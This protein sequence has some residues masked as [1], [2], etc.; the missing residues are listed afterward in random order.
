MQK[1]ETH[2]VFPHTVHSTVFVIFQ[3]L[4]AL[5]WI[6]KQGCFAK[7]HVVCLYNVVHIMLGGKGM[8]RRRNLDAAAA[9]QNCRKILMFLLCKYVYTPAWNS[10]Y[11]RLRNH[12][13]CTT[14]CCCFSMWHNFSQKNAWICVIFS[15]S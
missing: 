6:P 2:T 11:R 14:N 10:H 4:P 8:L 12:P 5:F 13:I 1:A 15:I 9:I 3:F 7:V